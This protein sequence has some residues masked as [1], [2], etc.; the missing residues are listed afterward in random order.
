MRVT[1]EEILISVRPVFWKASAWISVTVSG[2]D[3]AVRLE[4]SAKAISLMEVMP[5]SMTT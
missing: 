3:T 4:Q 1:A 5:D 2:M